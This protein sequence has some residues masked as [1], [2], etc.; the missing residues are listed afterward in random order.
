MPR[1]MFVATLPDAEVAI[2]GV[3]IA[4]V[5][6]AGVVIAGVVIAGVVILI[7]EAEAPLHKSESQAQTPF[8]NLLS[9]FQAMLMLP[10]YLPSVIGPAI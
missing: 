6:I 3:V 10:Q 1:N 7:F 4:G 8:S 2:A 5:V 9:Q